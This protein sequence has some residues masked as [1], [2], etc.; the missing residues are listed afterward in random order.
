MLF[1]GFIRRSLFDYT[2]DHEDEEDAYRHITNVM[3]Q[4]QHPDYEKYKDDSIWEFDK[5]NEYMLKE[6][7]Y[8]PKQI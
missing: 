3:L 1:P 5:V 4:R 7:K 6:L 2:V 8:D